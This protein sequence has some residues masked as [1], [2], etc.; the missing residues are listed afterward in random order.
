MENLAFALFVYF[1][2]F[3]VQDFGVPLQLQGNTFSGSLGNQ[4]HPFHKSLTNVHFLNFSFILFRPKFAD[5]TLIVGTHTFRVSWQ[6]VPSIPQKLNKWYIFLTFPLYFSVQDLRVPHQ[7]QRHTLSVSL[8]SQLHRFHKSLINVHFLNFSCILFRPDFAS[9]TL[10]V[11]THTFRVSWQL[12]P[13]IPRKL[14]KWYIF[15]TFPL[16]FSV[17]TLQVPP[18]LSG[19]ALS[20]SLGSQFHPFHKNLI[21]GTFS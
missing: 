12:A 5:P 15:L 10:V 19:H 8:G 17:Q 9:P 14:D 3:S 20:G 13:S 2:N 11:G 6:L 7:L 1:L 21:N 4:F 16:Y 18:Q